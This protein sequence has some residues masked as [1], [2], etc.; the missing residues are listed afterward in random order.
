MYNYCYHNNYLCRLLLIEQEHHLHRIY[1]VQKHNPIKLPLNCKYNPRKFKEICRQL[2]LYFAKKL[3]TFTVPISTEGTI[4]EQQVW[5]A[6]QKITYGKTLSYGVL[7]KKIKNPYAAKAVGHAANK[8]PLPIII[9]CHRLIGT[10]G[11]LVG[12]NAGLP[13]KMSLLKLEGY[14]T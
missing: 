2:D 7:A 14:F 9:P 4:F 3:Q 10:K 6:L 11:D 1:F 12:F 13:I 5:K 8:N